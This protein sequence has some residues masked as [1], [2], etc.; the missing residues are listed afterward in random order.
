MDIDIVNDY[1]KKYKVGPL[2]I[3]R[4]FFVVGKYSEDA[5]IVVV[6]KRL[7][8][9]ILTSDSYYRLFNGIPV[10]IEVLNRHGETQA[11]FHYI[12]LYRSL[13]EPYLVADLNSQM[14]LVN[15][16]YD[17][18][19]SNYTSKQVNQENFNSLTELLKR[20]SLDLLMSTGSS[21][22]LSD[23]T[24]FYYNINPQYLEYY[25]RVSLKE[26]EDYMVYRNYNNSLGLARGFLARK[27]E[28]ILAYDKEREPEGEENDEELTDTRSTGSPDM[29]DK[30]E[31][32]LNSNSVITAAKLSQP[33]IVSYFRCRWYLIYASSLNNDYKGVMSDFDKIVEENCLGNL[34]V[35][36]SQVLSEQFSNELVL[37]VNLLR[38][39]CLSVLIVKR[40][41][42]L[43][44]YWKIPLLKS[45]ILSDPLL[46]GLIK[47][48]SS[49][50]FDQSLKILAKMD[51]EYRYDYQI[52]TIFPDMQRILRYKAYITYLSLVMRV[53][54]EHM[55][56]MF[57]VDV[58][59]LYDE[60]V[61][62]ID[63]F[64][65]QF[66]MDVTNRIVEF[67]PSSSRLHKMGQELEAI[68]EEVKIGSRSLEVNS[69]VQGT[70]PEKDN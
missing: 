45:A 53:S 26:F 43:V 67:S 65:L 55:A 6:V 64:G 20:K 7:L 15:K 29:L 57:G 3:R 58:N 49:C 21:E 13:A 5:R 52:S 46:N 28:Q 25:K 16:K 36:A 61:M 22:Y 38:I 18:D 32:V 39:I 31:L 1:I 69:I 9:L 63:M 24:S 2:F 4:L 48:Y 34:G 35:S 30:D 62:V 40:S 60:L 17:G 33:E 41:S 50:K 47:S 23:N 14:A 54:V 37:S 19:I 8:E 42:E 12:D 66:K 27:L 56:G 51:E 68:D 59:V 44:R 10:L 11:A 70:F